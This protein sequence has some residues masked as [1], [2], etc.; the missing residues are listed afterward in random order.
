MSGEMVEHHGNFHDFAPLQMSP[1]TT[2]P[3]PFFIG[4]DSDAA[5]RR[6]AQFD[7]WLGIRYTEEQL[8]GILARLH[9]AREAAGTLDRPFDVWS[10][11]LNPG[12]GTFERVEAMG[13]TMT[14]GANFMV[15]GKIVPTSID[16]KKERIEAFAR[17]FIC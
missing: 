14:N 5:F 10:A 4:G 17:Q 13:V 3:V 11:I 9:T 15:D 8:T 1:G 16:F 2:Q 12:E 6:A 7:G